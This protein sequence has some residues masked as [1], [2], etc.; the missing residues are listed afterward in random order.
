MM[1]EG[2]AAYDGPFRAELFAA[3]VFHDIVYEADREDNEERSAK[4]ARDWLTGEVD[5]DLV[6]MAILASKTHRLGDYAADDGHQATILFFLRLDLAALW[7]EKRPLYETYAQGIRKEYAHAPNEVFRAGRAA[8]LG[9][10]YDEI[11]PHMREQEGRY[12]GRNF[13]WE[14]E[15]LAQGKLDL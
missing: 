7:T 3:I 12:L 1:L 10:L 15:A 4:K 5:I 11:R 14:R 8:V 13:E 2:F 6:A 9:R